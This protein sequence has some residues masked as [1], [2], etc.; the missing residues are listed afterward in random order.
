[1][2][3]KDM[4]IPFNEKNIVFARFL[5]RPNRFIIRCKLEHSED[6]VEAHL[7]DSGRLKELLLPN[8]RLMLRSVD[9]PKRK[10]KF[11][12]VAVEKENGPGWVSLN[13]NLPNE[14]AK[15]AIENQFFSEL[16]HWSY[17]RSEFTKGNSRWDLLLE[18]ATS[19]MLVEVKGVTLL[20]QDHVGL[21]PDAITVRG[22]KHVKELKQ[23]SRESGWEA[24]IIFV[25]QRDDIHEIKTAE[26][27][28]PHFSAALRD[29]KEAGVKLLAFNCSVTEKGI[30]IQEKVKVSP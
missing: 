1:M 6:T 24:A 11:S 16:S 25:A 15:L 26:H 13:S 17:V 27:I 2:I 23:I 7:A 22:T 29:A 3:V 4:F 30:S 9:D 21:F 8:K 5:E 14:L 20:S 28:D 12:S 10:T 18:N 19:Q